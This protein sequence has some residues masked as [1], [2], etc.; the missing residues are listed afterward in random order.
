MNKTELV[1][2]VAQKA[3]MTQKDAEKTINAIFA[4]IENALVKKDRVQIIGFGTFETRVREARKGRNP[5][6]KEEIN[7]PASKHPVF[8]P[9][10]GLKDAVNK[11]K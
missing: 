3:E 6:T 9:G 1:K 2:A 5:R 7:I 8:K 10:K 11:K 4:V